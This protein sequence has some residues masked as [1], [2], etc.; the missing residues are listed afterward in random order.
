LQARLE[1]AAKELEREEKHYDLGTS[2]LQVVVRKQI[3]LLELKR[4]LAA[5]EAGLAAP[6]LQP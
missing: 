1:L 3:R 2:R 6:H 4:E 5:F